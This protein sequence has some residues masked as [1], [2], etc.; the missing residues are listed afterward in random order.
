MMSKRY[1][2]KNKT[3]FMLTDELNEIKILLINLLI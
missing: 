3:E 2:N 1:Y